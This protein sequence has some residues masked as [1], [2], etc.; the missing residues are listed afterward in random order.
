M[1]IVNLQVGPICALKV[2][3]EVNETVSNWIK[4][5]ELPAA[6]LEVNGSDRKGV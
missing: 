4:R 5:I 6:S 3:R 1:N 2:N